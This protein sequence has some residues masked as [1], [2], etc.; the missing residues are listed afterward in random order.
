MLKF[1]VKFKPSKYPNSL[2]TIEIYLIKFK[3]ITEILFNLPRISAT[4]LNTVI[5]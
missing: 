1:R 2:N 4:N 3:L 5:N